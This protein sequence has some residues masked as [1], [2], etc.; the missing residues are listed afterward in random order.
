VR[1]RSLVLTLLLCLPPPALAGGRAAALAAAAPGLEPAVLER[2]LEALECA[3]A[4]GAAPRAERLAVIDYSRP[5]TEPRLW[6]FDLARARLLYAE[7]VAHGRNSGGDLATAFSNAEG[8]HQSSLGLF[9]T[10]D[11]YVG[12]NGYS[13]R[14]DGLDPGFNDRARERY[15]VMHGAPYVD[16]AAARRQGRLGR[17]QGCPAVRPQ[18][19]RELI[20][21]LR[22]GQLIF[23]WYPDPQWLAASPHLGCAA[24]LARHEAPSPGAAPGRDG[25]TATP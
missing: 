21:T 22:D 8:S 6:V 9:R 2:A 13:L 15:I 25:V 17:S 20:D 18:V 12:G 3:R 7:H 10:A 14:L 4:S 19:A 1:C 16:P 24:R 5:S 11:T 23:A